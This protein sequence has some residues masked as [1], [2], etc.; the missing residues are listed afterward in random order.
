MEPQSVL[1][2]PYENFVFALN[3]KESKRQYPHRLDKFLTFVGLEGT[4]EEK[5]L[6]LYDLSQKDTNLLQAYLK[7][8]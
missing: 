3:A 7:G 5:C 1:L 4:I 2:T 6:K 8:S